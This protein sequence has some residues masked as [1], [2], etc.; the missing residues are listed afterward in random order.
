MSREGLSTERLQVPKDDFG[1]T[2]E[3]ILTAD[4][5]LLNS[6]MPLKKLAPYRESNPQVHGVADRH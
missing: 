4:E 3:E 6:F 1:L 5:K 2:T